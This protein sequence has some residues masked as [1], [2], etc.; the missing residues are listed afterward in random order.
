MEFVKRLTA[1]LVTPGTFET[2]FSTRATQAA[3]LIPETEYLSIKASKK[4]KFSSVLTWRIDA[5]FL[6]AYSI[7]RFRKKTQ[8]SNY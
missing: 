8:H 7:Y 3:Q 1:Q 6:P 5:L 4:Q 2:A